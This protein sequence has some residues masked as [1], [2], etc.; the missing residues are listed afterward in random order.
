[1]IIAQAFEH[2]DTQPIIDGLRAHLG[3]DEL[4]LSFHAAPDV[5]WNVLEMICDLG[6]ISPEGYTRANKDMRLFDGVC[7]AAYGPT[8]DLNLYFKPGLHSI[9]SVACIDV[10]PT[11]MI[12]TNIILR[13]KYDMSPII[14]SFGGTV[15]QAMQGAD[16]V[17]VSTAKEDGISESVMDITNE[18]YDL[19]QLPYVKYLLA[20]WNLT[21]NEHINSAIEETGRSA[22]AVALTG[23]ESR[24]AGTLSDEA[25][26]EIPGH[27]RYTFE[28]EVLEG[29]E[30]FFRFAFFHGLHKDIPDVKFWAPEPADGGQEA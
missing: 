29:L 27:Y 9:T 11:D 12:L 26:H 22:D 17:L 20:G 21:I 8:D 28:D 15:E 5:E 10:S 2:S 14:K 3:E 18:W 1:M 24:L 7:V 23:L 16:A 30:Q 13:E 4:E 19:T 25:E 6:I